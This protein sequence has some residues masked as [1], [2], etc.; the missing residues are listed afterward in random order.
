MSKSDKINLIR[1]VADLHFNARI[2]ALHCQAKVS[3]PFYISCSSR[4]ESLSQGFQN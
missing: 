3:S 2:S 4:L 1:L